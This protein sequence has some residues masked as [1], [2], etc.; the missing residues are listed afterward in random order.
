M[1]LRIV[2]IHPASEKNALNTEWFVIENAGDTVFNTKNCTL[3]VSRGNSKKRRDLGTMDPGFTIGPGERVR[4]ITGNPG[5]KAHGK[6]PEDQV[7]NY[8]L[9]LAASVLQGEGTVL[10]LA[11]RA[12]HLASAVFDP[13]AKNGVGEEAAG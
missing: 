10:H 5:R 12:H 13:E 3:S 6:A 1:E 4:V 8:N 2:E 9:F 11:L 7:K